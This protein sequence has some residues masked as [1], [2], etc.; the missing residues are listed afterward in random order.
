VNYTGLGNILIVIG[1]FIWGLYALAR[2][3]LAYSGQVTPFLIVHLFFVVPGAFLA[4]RGWTQRLKGMFASGESVD[5]S[6]S[7]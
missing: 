7:R 2:F 4:G 3:Q 1:V 6:R 5:E